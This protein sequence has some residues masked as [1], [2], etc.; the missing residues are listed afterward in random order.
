MYGREITQSRKI[1]GMRGPFLSVVCGLKLTFPL[2][3]FATDPTLTVK[4]SG[5][6]VKMVYEYPPLLREIQDIVERAT[7]TKFNHCML[8][9]YE[10][11]D[12]YIGKHRDLLQNK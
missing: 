9:Y 4:Y 2:A 3:A 11:G 6:P 1:A 5:H 8:N 10:D 12:V 7:G